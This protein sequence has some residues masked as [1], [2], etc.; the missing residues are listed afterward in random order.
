MTTTSRLEGQSGSVAIKVPCRVAT[1]TNITLSGLQTIDTVSLVADERVLVK[2]QTTASENGIYEVNTGAWVRARDFNGARDIVQG[3]EVRV[4]SGAGS[5]TYYVS[6][7]NP[8]IIGTTSISFTKDTVG[9]ITDSDDIT[10]GSVNLFM[11]VSERSKLAGIDPLAAAN[12]QSDWGDTVTGNDSYILNKPTLGTISSQDAN[13]V[14]ISGGNATLTGA[15]ITNL[16]FDGV[17]H[18]ATTGAD[19]SLV[20]GT[21]G[22]SGNL[23]EWNGNGDIVDSGVASSDFLTSSDIGTSIQAY[24]ADILKADTTDTLT[25]GFAT[26]SYNAGTKSS[27]TY[28]PDEANGQFQY[29]INGGAHTLAPP[30]NDTAITIQYTN[31]ASAGTITT[32]G[33][34][35]VTGDALTTTNGDDFL[36]DIRK[37]NGFSQLHVTALQ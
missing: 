21:A 35:V 37:I 31:N 34:T 24:D 14:T 36:C 17:T 33:F 23:A 27:G 30:T 19:T 26:T 3:T 16:I 11:S 18:T 10:Q 9:S 29:A 7:A 28:T 25:V 12:V 32:T 22:T 8:I 6:T 5:G 20:S 2:N 15:S 13:D 4:I 1:T